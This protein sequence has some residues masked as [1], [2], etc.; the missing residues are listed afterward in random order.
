M[1]ALAVAI[2]VSVG[3]PLALAQSYSA[4]GHVGYLGEWVS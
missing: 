4:S 3:A 1:G 2:L